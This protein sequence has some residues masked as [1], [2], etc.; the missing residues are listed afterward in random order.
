[1]TVQLGDHF[2]QRRLGNGGVTAITVEHVFLFF[3]VFQNLGFQVSAATDIHD[4]ED[5]GDCVMV[6]DGFIA[7][8]QLTE[9]TEQMFKSQ[10]SPYAFVEWILV[11]DHWGIFIGVE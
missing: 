11:K 10:V 7:L 8:G 3:K 2:V 4:L 6:I 9:A 5:R 1:M